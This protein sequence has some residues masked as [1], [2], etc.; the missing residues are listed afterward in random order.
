[1]HKLQIGDVTIASIIERDGP[2]RP[3]E[4]M[5]PTCDPVLARKHLAE[6]DP[7]VWDPASGKLVMPYQTFVVRTPRHTILI[8]TCTGEHKGYGPPWNFSPQ[9][10][11]DG[12]RA[13]GLKFSDIDY[14]F[15]THLHIDH[16]GW[17]TQLVDGRWVPTFPKAKYVFHRQEYAYWEEQA[18]SGQSAGGGQAGVW[19]M[20]CE[21]IVEAGQAL[22]IDESYALDDTFFL[23]L[24]PGHTPYHCCVHFRSKGQ[25]AIVVGDLMH[26]ALQCREP[27]WSTGFCTDPGQAAQSRRRFLS[28]YAGSPTLMLP[29]HFP[30]P[31]AG[32]IEPDGAR[33]RYRFVG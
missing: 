16:T 21:P 5:F 17:N 20:N 26:H 7:F 13:L 33:F 29:V 22:L 23:S 12:F 2:W 10:W 3:I 6:M 24:T 8:D 14:V 18:R 11:L 27:D 9:P 4:N 32:R 19:T 15:C 30:H 1:M 28:T 31:T 25:E